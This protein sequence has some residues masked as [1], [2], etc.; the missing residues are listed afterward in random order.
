MRTG[1]T[2][3][4]WVSVVWREGARSRGWNRVRFQPDWDQLP[5]S[6]RT[7]VAVIHKVYLGYMRFSGG[8]P[9]WSGVTTDWCT[10]AAKT[11]HGGPR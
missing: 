3:V 8:L 7:G 11:R 6:T 9:N 2:L 5:N 10:I 1:T 4:S